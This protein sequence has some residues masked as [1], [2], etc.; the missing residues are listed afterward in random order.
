VKS[1]LRNLLLALLLILLFVTGGFFLYTNW[2]VEKPFAVILFLS[3]SLTPG[4]LAAARLYSGGANAS[5]AMESLSGLALLRSASAD[6]PAADEAA[7]ASAI[8]TGHEV[9]QGRISVGANGTALPTLLQ[10]AAAR[11][12]SI[13]LI[14]NG[15]L[16]SPSLA[17]FYAPGADARNADQLTAILI[18]QVRPEVILAGGSSELLPEV[19]GGQRR[20]GR[21]L[22]LTARQSGYDIVRNR[23]ELLN[24]P[25]WRAPQVL[26]L[27]ASGDL[28]FAG[29]LGAAGPEPSLAEMVRQAIQLLQFNRKGYFLVVDAAL[30]GRAA[31]ANDGETLLR[32]LLE[33]DHAVATAIQYAGENLLL[34]VCGTTNPGGF[35]LNCNGFREDSGFAIL[36]RASDGVPAVTWSTGTGGQGAGTGEPL[37]PV[38]FTTTI[39]AQIVTDM[40]GLSHGK[41]AALLTGFR[42]QRDV[43]LLLDNGL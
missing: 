36:G 4:T 39:P 14:T 7:A 15:R 1:K 9:N 21:D 42:R 37:E 28:S 34:A 16:S 43:F 29:R 11:G 40:L 12:R 41:T 19:K 18:D 25:I 20:D 27:F 31:V 2:V 33:L 23:Q 35:Q 13:G 32:E 8:A 17:A 5:L 24:T 22:M 10:K 26:G 30:V 38:A 6:R 3:Q